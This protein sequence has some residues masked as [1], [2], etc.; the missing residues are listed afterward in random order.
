[1]SYQKESLFFKIVL[2]YKNV[3]KIDIQYAIVALSMS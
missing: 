3:N 1:M 2:P